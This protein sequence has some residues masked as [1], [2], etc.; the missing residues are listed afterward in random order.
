MSKIFGGVYE[1]MKFPEYKFQ[2]YPKMLY[3]DRG[4]PVVVDNHAEELRVAERVVPVENVDA[5]IEELKKIQ[6]ATEKALAEAQAKQKEEEE[7]RKAAE[8][9]LAKAQNKTTAPAPAVNKV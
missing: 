5:K 1:D 2:E 7:K 6:E 3:T 8:E 9:A 4:V